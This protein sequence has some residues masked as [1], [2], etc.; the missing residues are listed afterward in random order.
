MP[1]TCWP[2][3]GYINSCDDGLQQEWI[4]CTLRPDDDTVIRLLRHGMRFLWRESLQAEMRLVF[5]A[6]VLTVTAMA[7]VGLLTN[8]IGKTLVNQSNELLGADLV[9]ASSRA[10]PDAWVSQAITTGLQT[11][12]FQ[13]FPSVLVTAGDTSLVEVKAIAEGY[14]LR[15]Q[16]LLSDGRHRYVATGL[17]RSGQ[18]WVEKD[19]L[20]KLALQPGDRVTLGTMDFEIAAILEHEPDRGGSLFSLAP[21]VMMNAADVP[22]TGLVGEGSRIQ[23]RLLL[24]GDEAAISAY[25]TALQPLLGNHYQI[26]SVRDSRPEVKAS[27]ERAERFLALSLLVTIMLACLAIWVATQ[28][29]VQKRLINTAVLRTIGLT[30]LQISGLYLFQLLLLCCAACMVAVLISM[31]L[32]SLLVDVLQQYM[33]SELPAAD[34][35][36]ALWACLLGLLLVLAFSLPAYWR[37]ISVSPMWVLRTMPDELQQVRWSLGF[38]LIV[39]CMILYAVTRDLQ[40]MGMAIVALVIVLLVLLAMSG[41]MLF[42]LRGVATGLASNMPG[43][44]KLGIQALIRHRRE[45][46]MAISVF[47][48]SFFFIILLTLIRTDL[49]EQ[50]RDRL[51]VETPNTFLVNIQPG[52]LDGVQNWLAGKGLTE[53]EFYPMIRGRLVKINGQRITV[54]DYTGARAKRMLRREFNLSWTNQLPSHNQLT[55]GDWWMPDADKQQWSVEAGIAEVLDIKPGD[56]ITYDVAG[57][58]VS[59]EVTSLREVSWDS[60]KVNFFVIGTKV[61]MVQL[62]TRYI[63]SFYLKIENN[64][65]MD[66]LVRHYPSVTVLDVNALMMRVRTVIDKVSYAAEAAFFFT[67]MASVLLVIAMVMSTRRIRRHENALMRSMGAT[68]SLLGQAQNIEFLLI[69]FSAGLIAVILANIAAWW[70]SVELLELAFRF[71]FIL[72]VGVVMAGMALVMLTGWGVLRG[73]YKQRPMVLLK[74]N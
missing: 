63:S 51:P 27:L 33:S 4:G 28:N 23:Y 37:L 49:L 38:G 62:P 59:G 3:A 61:M 9:I 47:G 71:N 74:A 19:L 11:S 44:I 41:L 15:G 40:L 58:E 54:E 21:R 65:F 64:H 20:R 34:I 7:T 36:P 66:E 60:F 2:Q 56:V 29:W 67:L 52:E 55:Y 13:E 12:Q 68:Q 42:T 16:L 18:V 17:P 22:A 46:L 31:G 10:I 57:Q 30:R 35:A 45:T 53:I 14:P 48:L 8:R 5:L 1:T 26:Q 70:V 50:W 24:A 72:A 39:L 6:L 43:N 69:G 73:Q 32:Q 25:K